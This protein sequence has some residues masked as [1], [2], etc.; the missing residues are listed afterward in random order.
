M[1]A[2][3]RVRGRNSK[4]FEPN[5]CLS[6]HPDEGDSGGTCFSR[7][8]GYPPGLHAFIA[9]IDFIKHPQFPK[10]RHGLDILCKLGQGSLQAGASPELSGRW[11]RATQW[12]E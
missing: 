1:L 3:R 10:Y 12:G 2:C 8:P 7:D 5:S 11:E 6:K 9:H 4:A